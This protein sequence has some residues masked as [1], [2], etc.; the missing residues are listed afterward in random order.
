MCY[1][2]GQ[3]VWFDT[4]AWYTTLKKP[5]TP[6]GIPQCYFETYKKFGITILFNCRHHLI[7]KTRKQ[8][9]ICNYNCSGCVDGRCVGVG[10]VVG[11]KREAATR[12][13]SVKLLGSWVLCVAAGRDGQ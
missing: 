10:L 11:R 8:D 6:P 5:R 7:M 12:P 1:H 13:R 4:V 3:Q 9:G 2:E